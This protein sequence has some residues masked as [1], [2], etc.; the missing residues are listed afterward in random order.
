MIIK[1]PHKGWIEN[2]AGEKLS[3]AQ[4]VSETIYFRCMEGFGAPAINSSQC[5]NGKWEFEV[6]DCI[7]HCPPLNST[8][9]P[10]K[11]SYNGEE[12]TCL[13]TTRSGSKALVSCPEQID[14]YKREMYCEADGNW[15]WSD[16]SRS[17]DPP[18]GKLNSGR[19]SWLVAIYARID[20]DNYYLKRLEYLCSG[21]ILNSTKVITD[22]ACLENYTASELLVVA[23]SRAQE[24]NYP[25]F[26][27]SLLRAAP[28]QAQKLIQEELWSDRDVRRIEPNMHGKGFAV[29][30]IEKSFQF[31]EFVAPICIADTHVEL[32]QYGLM[33]SWRKWN[34]PDDDTTSTKFFNIAT[35]ASEE[36][37]DPANLSPANRDY[38]C[39]RKQDAYNAACFNILG[40]GLIVPAINDEE[41]FYLRG[42]VV[43]SPVEDNVCIRTAYPFFSR[44][45]KL[46]IIE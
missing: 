16:I 24:I 45:D 1:L 12:S 5:Q 18:C 2:L 7:V 6:P 28:E 15:M 13:N 38:Y 14:D 31:N 43:K 37:A 26:Y 9:L 8:Y 30:T 20:K 40:G 27:R 10:A 34:S 4:H 39:Q 42:I 44:F 33:V 36:C 21:T 25:R 11:C 22:L 17:C 23:G 29:L 41:T 32:K 35:F 3:L 46:D 19:G